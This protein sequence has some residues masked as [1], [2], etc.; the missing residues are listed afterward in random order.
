MA[1]NK[2]QDRRKVYF[3]EIKKVLRPE[4]ATGLG[5]SVFLRNKKGFTP[6]TS[7]RTWQSPGTWPL[8]QPCTVPGCRCLILG[9]IRD[10]KYGPIWTWMDH[11][12]V[13]RRQS[14]A[15]FRSGSILIGPGVQNCHKR[16]KKQKICFFTGPWRPKPGLGGTNLGPRGHFLSFWSQSGP[17]GR[18]LDFSG[19]GER[20]LTF[21]VN[22]FLVSKVGVF[23][24]FRAC[25]HSALT[26][27]QCPH[28][29]VGKWGKEVC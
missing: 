10:T 9:P 6:R 12:E 24:L 18:F 22:T 25:W 5:K 19:L 20:T 27:R 16:F 17:R 23:P 15:K 29:T 13:W 3:W 8:G 28:S 2:Q 7:N 11:F 26:L 21:L 1:L 14:G 4:Q